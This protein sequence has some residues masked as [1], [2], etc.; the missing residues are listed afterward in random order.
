LFSRVRPS[1][2]AMRFVF[3]LTLSKVEGGGENLL[4]FK[5][6]LRTNKRILTQ[7]SLEKVRATRQHTDAAETPFLIIIIIVII[8]NSARSIIIY[9]NNHFSLLL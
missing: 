1:Y 8:S 2:G 7:K 3:L 4:F 6:F 9:S 5:E